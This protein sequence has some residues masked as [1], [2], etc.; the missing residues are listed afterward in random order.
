MPLD[1][2]DSPSTND[3]FAAGTANVG[4]RFMYATPVYIY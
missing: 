4:S 2:P 1:F 3:T